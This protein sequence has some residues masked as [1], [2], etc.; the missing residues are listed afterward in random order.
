MGGVSASVWIQVG[1]LVP[2]LFAGWFWL[3]VECVV[4]MTTT[5]LM[6]SRFSVLATGGTVFGMF[7]IAFIGRWVEVIGAQIGNQ[8]A[9]NIGIIA[10]LMM[11]SET[12]WRYASQQMSSPLSGVMGLSPFSAGPSPSTAMMIYVI[13]YILV[14]MVMAVRVFANRDL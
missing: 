6:G 1:Y 4:L 8:S 3:L 7:G 5:L 12:I 2:R 13:L 14:S 10:S 9:I 11:P